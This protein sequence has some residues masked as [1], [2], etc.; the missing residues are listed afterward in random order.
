MSDEHIN[1][2]S[3]RSNLINFNALPEALKHYKHIPDNNIYT[4]GL[5]NVEKKELILKHLRNHQKGNMGKFQQIFPTLT[6]YK[7]HPLLKSLKEKGQVK[8]IGTPKT[9]YWV[10]TG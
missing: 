6:R 8:H 9:G 3:I 10:L 1:S 4:R 7:I 5:G 2:F